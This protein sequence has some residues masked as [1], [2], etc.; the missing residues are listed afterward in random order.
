[1]KL[2]AIETATEACSCALVAGWMQ[3]T[4]HEIAPRRHAELVLAMIE[5]LLRQSGYGLRDLDGIAFGRGP[6]AFTGVRIAAGVAQGLAFGAELP[7]APVSSLQALAQGAYRESGARRV[8]TAL[9]ARM[10]EVYWGAFELGARGYMVAL[11]EESVCAPADVP[12]PPDVTGWLAAG[13]GWQRHGA[14]LRRALGARLVGA[15]AQRCPHALDVAALGADLLR[16]GGGV[17]PEAALPVYLR[18]RVVRARNQH[19]VKDRS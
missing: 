4:A 19:P 16:R 8:L 7:V 9:D 6:G 17:A 15:Q 3:W 12:L 18:D 5:R 13:S 11:L 10:D 1:M 2:L 14:A